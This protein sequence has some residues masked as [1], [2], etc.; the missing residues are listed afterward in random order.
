MPVK[1]HNL[2]MQHCFI[3]LVSHSANFSH[4]SSWPFIFFAPLTPQRPA[5]QRL[6]STKLLTAGVR[7]TPAYPVVLKDQG[8]P[9]L[10]EKKNIAHMSFFLTKAGAHIISFKVWLIDKM[11]QFSLAQDW[12]DGHGLISQW[13][14]AVC[15][16][17]PVDKVWADGPAHRDKN[18][19][20][21]FDGELQ[22]CDLHSSYSCQSLHCM[23]SGGGGR[24][25]LDCVL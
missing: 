2:F 19:L 8:W 16:R 20:R 4:Q 12:V 24:A 10:P 13:Q 21:S 6:A 1:T 22:A 17:L 23:T 5:T 15:V 3:S 14:Q 7:Q 25:Y 9:R 11:W 18:S